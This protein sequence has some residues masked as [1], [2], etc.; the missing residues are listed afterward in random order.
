[1]QAATA[2]VEIGDEP[3]FRRVCETMRARHPA[4]IFERWVA[5]SLA[6]LVTLAPGGVGDDGKV[7]GWIEP[8][9]ATVDPA[10]PAIK[11]GLLH[12]LGAV[13]YRSGR[14]REAIARLEEAIAVGGGSLSPIEAIFLAMA[15]FRTGGPAKAR[16]LLSGP[17]RDEPDGLSAE[18][19][20]AWRGHRLLR[21]EAERLILDPEFPANPFSP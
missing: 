2:H 16:A 15:H 10:R 19:W 12:T 11:R 14:H 7:L 8:L 3:G 1:M 18:A 4:E 20:W 6:D 9:P 5:A 21:H 13:L 17:W